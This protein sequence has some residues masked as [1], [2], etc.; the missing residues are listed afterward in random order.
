M[1][2]WNQLSS[3][4]VTKPV[5]GGEANKLHKE[6]GVKERAIPIKPR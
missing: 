2:I 5:E 1:N 4:R 6:Q 3:R